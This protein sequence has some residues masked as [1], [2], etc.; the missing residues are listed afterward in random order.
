MLRI[1]HCENYFSLGNWVLFTVQ[2]K[3]FLFRGN[4]IYPAMQCSHSMRGRDWEKVA[5]SW[6]FCLVYI[7]SSSSHLPT[8]LSARPAPPPYNYKSHEIAPRSIQ[9]WQFLHFE[10]TCL[11]RHLLGLLILKFILETSSGKNVALKFSRKAGE[12]ETK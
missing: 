1:K 2:A 6:C 9:H 10:F 4:N 11:R 8:T 7:N 12:N 3:H 5:F